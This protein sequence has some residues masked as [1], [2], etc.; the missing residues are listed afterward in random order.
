MSH[1]I[2]VITDVHGNYHALKAVLSRLDKFESVERIYCLGDMIALGPN[3]NE[4][5]SELFARSDVS[6]VLGNHEDA[7]LRLLDGQR[8][9][10]SEEAF[11]HHQWVAQGLAGQYADLL[12]KLP[13]S[14]TVRHGNST[15]RFLHYHLGDKEQFLPIEN[16]VTSERLDSLY[17]GQ[18]IQLVGFGHHHPVHL[19]RSPTRIYVNPGALG[20]NR[21]AQA[22]YAVVDITD[23]GPHVRLEHVTYD[24]TE[25]LQLYDKLDVPAKELILDM[26]HGERAL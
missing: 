9:D 5:L 3:T 18:D 2:A 17:A 11:L 8:S 20:C 10:E 25:F 7:V 23:T 13:R 12:R 14:L 24:N 6:M 19:L 16:D 1:A 26:F 22:R 15:F 4:V 21:Q